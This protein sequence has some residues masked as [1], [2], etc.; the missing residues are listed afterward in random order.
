MNLREAI[1]SL[2]DACRDASGRDLEEVV[3]PPL[4]YRELFREAGSFSAWLDDEP[5]FVLD[6]ILIRR[7]QE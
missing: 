3:L 2:N 4:A 5:S 6:G 7:G 1:D